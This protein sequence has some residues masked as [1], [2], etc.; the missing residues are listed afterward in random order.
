VKFS[1]DAVRA[2]GL[3]AGNERVRAFVAPPH[4]VQRPPDTGLGKRD[5]GQTRPGPQRHVPPLSGS[6]PTARIQLHAAGNNL[7]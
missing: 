7:K 4:A 5:A 3:V 2:A 6:L 1:G